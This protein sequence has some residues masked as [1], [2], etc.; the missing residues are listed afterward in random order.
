[1]KSV[2]LCGASAVALVTG[3]LSGQAYA[4][5]AAAAATASANAASEPTAIGELVVVAEK[6]N[7]KLETA[8]VAISAYTA[9]ARD[10]IGIKS[11]QDLSD[12]TPGLS[13]TTYSNRPYI[14]GIGRQTDNLAVESGVAVYV[15]GVYNGANATTILQT[16]TLFTDRI[17]VARGPQNTLYGRN[18][19]GGVIDYISRRPTRDFEGELRTGE[20]SYGKWFMEGA[21][22]GPITDWLRF[23]AGVNYT[24][25]NGGYYKNL[26]GPREGG[27]VA[28]GGNGQSYHYELQFDGNIGDHFDF[29]VKG[30]VSDYTTTFHTQTLIGPLD[31]RENYDGL[32]PNQNYGLCAFPG[33]QNGL[34]CVVNP[35]AGTYDK[36]LS[37][38]TLPNTIATNPSGVS[39]RDFDADF[40]SQ[41]Q[42]NKDLIVAA[43]FVYHMP[44]F[45]I[46]YLFGYQQFSFNLAA[47]WL[48]YE[49]ISSSV[50]SYVLQGPSTA[51]GLCT[52]IFNNAGCAQ[53][54]TV[55]PAK[56]Q[57]TFD[58]WANFS[59]HELDFTSTTNG[60]FQWL[61][62]L[63]YYHEYYSQPI[64]VIDPMQ[65]QVKSPVALS[66]FFGPAAPNPS[67]SVYNENTFLH[68]DSY[69]AYAQADYAFTPTLKFTGGVRYSE[70][71]KNGFE[72]FR[73]ILFN[74]SSAGLGAGTFGANTPAF[75]FTNL[76]IAGSC[77]VAYAGTGPCSINPATGL[78]MRGLGARWSAVTGVA[79]LA[80]TPDPD[81]LVYGKYSRGYKTGGFNS[82]TI[83][84]NPETQPEAVDA[85][86]I[87]FKK[88]VNREFQANLAA[89]YY[90]YYNDQQPLG[91]A[92]TGGVV[93]SQI[94]NIPQV[95]TYGVEL[96]TVWQP[97]R[98]LMLS[99][100]YAYIY[101]SITK[102]GQ[103]LEDTA[104]P[105]AL[106]NGANISG[107][108]AASN[109]IQLQ[110]ITG[111]Q[112]ASNPNNK[113]SFDGTYRFR[114]NPGDLTFA[115]SVVWK[116]K[117]YSSPFNRA[118]NT[119]P[120]YSQVNLRA[121]WTGADNRYTV[122]AFVNNLWQ[123]TG[124][125]NA[126][127]VPVTNPG[128]NQV[129]DTLVSLTAPRTFG[130]ELQYRFK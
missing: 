9:E 35:A 109:G 85:F 36:V 60:P 26:N 103:C 7:E 83:A 46:K 113:I 51:T 4:A 105:L 61:A 59:S 3:A 57:F 62:G 84:A 128:A 18:A 13:Y 45:D 54:L 127:G 107:C 95:N 114:F 56:T 77:A 32:M 125:D 97:T 93:S 110:N 43:N 24:Q 39:I 12:Y 30:A 87:G 1:M 74:L 15:D 91:V 130:L 21:A 78:A 52:L 112:I 5:E 120:A 16:D 63:Y 50:E 96:E 64:N 17:E 79:N 53:N 108:P 22:S 119:A 14:R 101:A 86:E 33:G 68:E 81:T 70:D 123:T 92:G 106:A 29:W 69:G 67:G 34:G 25:Q 117:Q 38:T 6:R 75:D 31:Q 129:I 2:F 44:T 118:Y 124:Y 71:Q 94:Y 66:P 122:I 42:Q 115:L 20:D 58:E 88:T 76:A 55:N 99:L 121:T 47:P 82:G 104:D 100:N 98:D 41:S 19:D 49:G 102:G 111:Q 28:G 89:F 23:R 10:L 40:K 37:V 8:P 126:Y 116:D 11:V 73:I 48:N 65:A 90:L 72:Q 80:W 27:S